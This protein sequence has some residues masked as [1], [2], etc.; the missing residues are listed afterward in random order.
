MAIL[1]DPLVHF[2]MTPTGTIKFA[3]FMY[4]IG[5][6]KNKPNT[7]ARTKRAGIAPARFVLELEFW[8]A[9][10]FLLMVSR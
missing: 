8:L 7:S 1:D 2:T 3:D 4:R 6:L 9:A 10:L 5:A